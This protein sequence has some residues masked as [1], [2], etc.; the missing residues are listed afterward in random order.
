MNR[1]PSSRTI[2]AGCGKD[3]DGSI[4][5]NE[6]GICKECYKRFN[7]DEQFGFSIDELYGEEH[8]TVSEKRDEDAQE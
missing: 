3:T 1:Y 6:R 4:T 7:L 8:E 5:I 2:C